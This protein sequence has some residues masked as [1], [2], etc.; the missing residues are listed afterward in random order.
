MCRERGGGGGGKIKSFSSPES[1]LT[2]GMQ[3]RLLHHQ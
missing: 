2:G 3:W 1:S